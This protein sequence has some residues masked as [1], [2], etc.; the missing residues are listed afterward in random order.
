PLRRAGLA[1]ASGRSHAH[2]RADGHDTTR[3]EPAWPPAA[4][5][6]ARAVSVPL[7]IV[8]RASEDR[9]LVEARVHGIRVGAAHGEPMTGLIGRRRPPRHRLLAF[10]VT[11]KLWKAV[12]SRELRVDRRV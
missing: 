4:L 7:H 3:T 12:G 2:G 5:H 8:R 1:P 6:S 9:R 11:I 10:H